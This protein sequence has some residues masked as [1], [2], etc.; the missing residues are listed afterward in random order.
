MLI[1]KLPTIYD[2]FSLLNTI[3]KFIIYFANISYVEVFN[4]IKIVSEET[5]VKIL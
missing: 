1:I 4:G 3:N 5:R 2:L